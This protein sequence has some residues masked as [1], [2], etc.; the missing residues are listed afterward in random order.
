MTSF[1]YLQSQNI[2]NVSFENHH[3]QVPV[4]PNIHVQ[5]DEAGVVYFNV[6]A[7]QEQYLQNISNQAGKPV[8]SLD[9]K[10]T[11]TNH[12]N[13]DIFELSSVKLCTNI[14]PLK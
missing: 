6:V 2:Q 10:I 12:C 7:Q 5:V 14:N 13:G 3:V 9:F 8:V 4:D 11:K 1:G